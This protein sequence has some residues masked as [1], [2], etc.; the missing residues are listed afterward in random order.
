[1]RNLNCSNSTIASQTSENS[2]KFNDNIN[3][4]ENFTSNLIYIFLL[5]M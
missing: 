3:Y 5:L 1:M 4:T 2:A